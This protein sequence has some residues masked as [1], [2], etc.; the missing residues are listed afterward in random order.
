[1]FEDIIVSSLSI[2]GIILITLA[3]LDHRR[4]KN[5]VTKFGLLSIGL[6]LFGLSFV[7]HYIMVDY[8]DAKYLFT[9]GLSIVLAVLCGFRW[10]YESGT[11]NP[12][13]FL[14]AN[15]KYCII[16]SVALKYHNWV[17]CYYFKAVAKYKKKD[18]KEDI[19]DIANDLLVVP[20]AYAI[21][22]ENFS[23]VP[24]KNSVFETDRKGKI[25]QDT[26]KGKAK[27][28]IIK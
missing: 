26:I 2:I 7:V 13:T 4:T 20:V 23:K 3:L 11:G 16:G 25:K 24:N 6:G 12:K 28:D 1:M 17:E 9:G 14:L 10:M 5:E 18:T 19:K 21:P 15:Q 8:T 22:T 27:Q